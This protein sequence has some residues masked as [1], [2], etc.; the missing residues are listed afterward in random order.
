MATKTCGRAKDF[1]GIIQRI[2]KA[3][4]NSTKKWHILKDN[5]T[6]WTLKSVSNTRWESRVESVK[7]IHFQCVEIREALLQIS[8][9]DN[10]PATSSEANGLAKNELGEYEFLLAIVIW[11]EVLHM[12]NVVS[13]CM[14][15]KD[16]LIDVA[17]EQVQ[18]LISFFKEYRETGFAKALEMGKKLHLRWIFKQHFKRSVKLKEKNIL[19]R[20][21]MKQVIDHSLR[22]THFESTILYLLLIKLFHLL[23]QDLN[24]IKVIK[25]I[26][27]FYLLLTYYNH[28]IMIA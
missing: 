2:Y 24:N 5:I 1:F 11:Y 19:M 23:Q 12:V 21:Q 8:E 9:I 6:G 20:A 14:Q 10:D 4:A 28:W 22:R 16:M 15:A 25:K 13:K 7:A 3:F 26:L 17:I 27:V 18:G